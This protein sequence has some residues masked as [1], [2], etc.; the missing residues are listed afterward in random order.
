MDTTLSC[1]FTPTSRM[2]PITVWYMWWHYSHHGLTVL[3]A[4]YSFAKPVT[5]RTNGVPHSFHA[6]F[7]IAHVERNKNKKLMP[8]KYKRRLF[9]FSQVDS[10]LECK[11]GTQNSLLACHY[12]LSVMNQCGNYTLMTYKARVINIHYERCF[13]VLYCVCT[14]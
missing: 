10:F 6:A 11:S 13:W 9:P 14:C 4:G 3:L 12:K 8:S 7:H 5:L 1:A 2:S